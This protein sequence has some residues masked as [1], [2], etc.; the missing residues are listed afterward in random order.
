MSEQPFNNTRTIYE[1]NFQLGYAVLL[2]VV[3][4]LI[5][6]SDPHWWAFG[7]MSIICWLVTGGLIFKSLRQ[8]WEIRSNY[9]KWRAFQARGKAPKQAK[10]ASK[11]AQQNGG[12]RL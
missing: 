1:I 2:A 10:L 5:W 7:A 11:Q 3:G 6:P 8:M 9:K 12:M 4:N